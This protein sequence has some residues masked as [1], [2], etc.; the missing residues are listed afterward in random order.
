MRGIED[1]HRVLQITH[2]LGVLL[3]FAWFLWWNGSQKR[4]LSAISVAE[5]RMQIIMPGHIQARD[6]SM[7]ADERPTCLVT[8]NC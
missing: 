4:E 2:P 1:L 3:F 6:N 8:E 5:K 7:H